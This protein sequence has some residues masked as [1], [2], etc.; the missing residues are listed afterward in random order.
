MSSLEAAFMADMTRRALVQNRVVDA[1]IAANMRA[2][3]FRPTPACRPL[4]TVW[5]GIMPPALVQNP[6]GETHDPF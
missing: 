3:A 4:K 1:A 6:A 2:E 5:P